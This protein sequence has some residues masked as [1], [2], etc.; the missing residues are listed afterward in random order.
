[1]LKQCSFLISISTRI[2]CNDSIT[3]STVSPFRSIRL[4]ISMHLWGRILRT[5]VSS[6]FQSVRRSAK[7]I[8]GPQ[9]QD[10][11]MLPTF[12]STTT[13]KLHQPIWEGWP[14]HFGR[15]LASLT[16]T[17]HDKHFTWLM[18]R[19]QL[20]HSQLTLGD[21]RDTTWT[22]RRSVTWMTHRDVLPFTRVDSSVL[23]YG[24]NQENP[25]NR[26]VVRRRR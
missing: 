24:C 14:C 20:R 4:L 12:S 7:V 1:M 8:D 9:K 22:G 21:K 18:A 17:Q 2:P 16:N 15:T 19:C 26:V 6:C 23:S 25:L 11:Y 3:L 5:L 13:M 10:S